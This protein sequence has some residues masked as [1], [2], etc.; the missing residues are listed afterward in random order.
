[1]HALSQSIGTLAVATIYCIWRM[2]TEVRLN[3]ERTLR[4][5]VAYMLWAA[6]SEIH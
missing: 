4:Q 5:R 1:M 3:Q 2:Y 6:A